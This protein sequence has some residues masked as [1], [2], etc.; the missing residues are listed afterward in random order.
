MYSGV[1]S[2]KVLDEELLYTKILGVNLFAF[3]C[4]CKQIN[5]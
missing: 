3:V 1:T 5:F 2:D 4:K